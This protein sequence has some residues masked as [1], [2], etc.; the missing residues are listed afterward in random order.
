MWKG[1]EGFFD[2]E[3]EYPGP[4]TDDLLSR[5]FVDIGIQVHQSLQNFQSHFSSWSD[6]NS[7]PMRDWQ[8]QIKALQEAYDRNPMRMPTIVSGRRHG[9]VSGLHPYFGWTD[10]AEQ[11]ITPVP[12]YEPPPNP[13]TPDPTT[14]AHTVTSTPKVYYKSPEGNY[15][16]IGEVKDFDWTQFKFA[17]SQSDTNDD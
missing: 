6:P 13:S 1:C 9:K 12:A 10:E 5:A 3:E 8:E 7:S 2:D 16:L 15:T 11:K 4:Y 17:D 14:G